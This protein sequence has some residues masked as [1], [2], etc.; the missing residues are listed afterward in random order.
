MELDEVTRWLDAVPMSGVIVELGAGS[1]WWSTLLASKG[2]LWAFEQD[3]AALEQA[4]QRLV[5]HDLLAH[6]HVRDPLAA[7]DQAVDVVFAAY[8]L[9]EA[10]D[11]AAMAERLRVVAG[12][13]RPG[14]TFAFVEAGPGAADGEPIDGPAGAMWPRR[15]AALRAALIEAGLAP[16]ELGQTHGAFVMGTAATAS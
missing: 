9:S 10:T 5:S 6:L 3:E 4:R 11:A 15:P 1:G 14:G 13:L 12:W 16:G 7:P 2:E 8:L